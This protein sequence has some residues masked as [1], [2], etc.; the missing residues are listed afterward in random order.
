MLLVAASSSS[1]LDGF[2]VQP[3][4]WYLEPLFESAIST[5]WGLVDVVATEAC[6]VFCTRELQFC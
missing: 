2:G 3:S 6:G 5:C 1:P 4:S